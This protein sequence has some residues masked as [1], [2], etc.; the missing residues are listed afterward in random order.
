MVNK[1][2]LVFIALNFLFVA[3]GGLVLALVLVTRASVGSAQTVSNVAQNLLLDHCPLI[4]AG[5]N[6]IF[7]FATFLLSIPAMA[8]TTHRTILRF[9][10]YAVVFCALFS[11]SIGL[12]IWF[13]T[14]KTRSNVAD[15][16]AQQTPSVQ[17]LLQQ[18]FQCCGYMSATSPPFVVDNTCTNSLVAA[19][20]QGCVTPFS[21]FANNYL[22]FVFTAAFGVTALDFLLL[23]SGA[24]L[25]KDRKER[26][27]F[28]LIDAK[29]EVPI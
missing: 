12:A 18:K 3:C 22:D 10:G 5:I 29:S 26:E 11:M 7:I 13:E 6:A 27:R 20:L 21:N 8:S 15:L 14:L 9:H 24:C 16:W 19:S 4:A 28:K 23:L 1:I 2:L 25:F 17:S